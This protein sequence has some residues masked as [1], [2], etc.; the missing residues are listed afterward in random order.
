MCS[1]HRVVSDAATRDAST[2]AAKSNQQLL[3]KSRQLEQQAQTLQQLRNK[4]TIHAKVCPV[5]ACAFRAA[6]LIMTAC[7]LVLGFPSR[8][9]VAPFR[10]SL[11][12]KSK[13]WSTLLRP[14]LAP[15]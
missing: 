4:C 2:S 3:A 1:R 15:L 5:C 8:R 9:N 6:A 13:H 11:S 12:K 14:W 10:R 7:T